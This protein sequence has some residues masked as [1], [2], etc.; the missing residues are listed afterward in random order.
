MRNTL[1][2][3]AVILLT[4]FFAFGQNEQAPIVEKEINYK[5]W[6]YKS[7][8]TG[9]DTNL[10]DLTVGKKLVIVVYYAPWCGNWRFDAPM[11]QRFY[12]KY[13]S[14]GLEIVAVGEYDP[15]SS[16]Q[17]NLTFMKI[18]FPAVYES[19]NRSEKQK[20]KH[21]DY[22]Q[23]TGDT[24]GWGSPWYIFLQPSLME[25]KGDTLTKKTFVINGEMIA[26]EGE[27]FI[28]EKLGLPAI[29]TKAATA[30]NGEVEVCDPADK[31][32]IELKKP[33]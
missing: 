29:D 24:R 19:E 32:T 15:V 30:K 4:A 8:R 17:N 26:D 33:L 9:E 25:K 27:K 3:F 13:K 12:D 1:F 23:S 5:N 10:R 18:T 16:M 6:T 2:A 14:A 28:R 11:L 22:R 20:T 7:V 21:Y 31:K